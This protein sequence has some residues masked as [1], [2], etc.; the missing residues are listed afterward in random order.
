MSVAGTAQD[1]KD[2]IQR[3]EEHARDAVRKVSPWIVRAARVGLVA[4]GCVY[5]VIGWIALQTAIV[6][7]RHVVDQ[8]GALRDVFHHTFGTVMLAALAVGLFAFM[9]WCLVRALFNPDRLPHVAKSYFK[10]TGLLF[11]ALAYCGLGIAATR[12]L[13]GIRHKSYSTR[14]WTRWLMGEPFG[15]WLVVAAGLGFVVYGGFR[16]YTAK[17]CATQND[18]VLDRVAARARPLIRALVW[19]GEFARAIVFTLIGLFAIS[20][21]WH[22]NPSEAKGFA[23]ALRYIAHKPYGLFMLGVVAA[24]LMAYGCYQFV[25]AKYRRIRGA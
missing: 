2:H 22:A 18:L 24:G 20:A 13:I 19:T 17:R 5:L 15:K 1:V 11:T 6:G 8:R 12:L 14:D 25:E 3:V 10:R 7:G 4:K 16:L 23:D 9:A 21:G